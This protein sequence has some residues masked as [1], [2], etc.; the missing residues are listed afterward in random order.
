[1]NSE[2]FQRLSSRIN[3]V[4]QNYSERTIAATRREKFNRVCIRNFRER[5]ISFQELLRNVRR[6]Y[7]KLHPPRQLVRSA[8]KPEH[9]VCDTR[10][11][12]SISAYER[13]EFLH[14]DLKLISLVQMP[15]ERY[16][17]GR[18]R[19]FARLFRKSLAP[20]LKAYLNIRVLSPYFYI[21]LKL[22]SKYLSQ[23]SFVR[24]LY[25]FTDLLC[26]I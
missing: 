19:V 12:P 22:H 18:G 7:W 20:K 21:F 14:F 23:K 26:T 8:I 9:H 17:G 10:R 2:I 6:R 15:G 25:L 3:S 16:W 11:A 13:I 5:E 4:C 24:I 1:M